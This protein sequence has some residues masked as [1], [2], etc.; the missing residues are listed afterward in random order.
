[1]RKNWPRTLAYLGRFR[2]QLEDRN[3]YTRYFKPSDPFYAIDNVSPETVAPVK[4]AWTA[5]GTAMQSTVVGL[6][7]LDG[8]I[9]E[10]P[11]V[12]K[13]TGISQP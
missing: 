4:V 6:T 12:F 1:M 13:N 11:T 5:K 10:K 7:S 3:G 8:T 9:A 2:D